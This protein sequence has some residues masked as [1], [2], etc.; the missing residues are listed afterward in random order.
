MRKCSASTG[1]QEC[2]SQEAIYQCPTCLMWF[3]TH[4]IHSDGCY[5]EALPKLSEFKL[6]GQDVILDPEVPDGQVRVNHL[7]LLNMATYC[8]KNKLN[9]VLESKA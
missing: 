8:L 4:H 1:P 7:T 6:L 2:F 9:G 3:C 5:K